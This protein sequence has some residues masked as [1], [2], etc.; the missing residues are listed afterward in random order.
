MGC[1]SNI[2][3]ETGLLRRYLIYNDIP[4]HLSQR[5]IRF[6]QHGLLGV[7]LFQ[8]FCMTRFHWPQGIDI[9]IH[10]SQG[11]MTR[12][13]PGILYSRSHRCFKWIA[14]SLQKVFVFFGETTWIEASYSVVFVSLPF[15]LN[16]KPKIQLLFAP[17]KKGFEST[18][19]LL[20]S[21][22]EPLN[23]ETLGNLP[24][25]PPNL[26]RYRIRNE[27]LSAGSHLPILDLLSQSL[28]GLGGGAVVDNLDEKTQ[29]QARSWK[30]HVC[31]FFFPT[32]RKVNVEDSK[33]N[34][35]MTNTIRYVRLF[36]T[37]F[38]GWHNP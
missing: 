22:P 31:L 10:D 33:I 13:K 36:E 37:F 5:I 34:N 7:I 29:V 18:S 4:L 2:V 30:K 14:F 25:I 35:E 17:P 8:V 27:A 9:Y 32:S 19:F 26:P 21:T 6:L 11:L 38:L 1:K 24:P 15:F 20:E 28:Q 12:L 3:S 23:A 16:T